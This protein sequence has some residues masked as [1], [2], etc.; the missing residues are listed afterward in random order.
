MG[1]LSGLQY[2]WEQCLNGLAMGSMYAVIA[3]GYSMV[4]GILE[5]INFAHGDVYMVGTFVALTLLWTGLPWWAAFPI[6]LMAGGLLAVL[7]ERLAYA[8]VR[9]GSRIVPMISAVGVAL[10]CRNLAQLTWGTSTYPSPVKVPAITVDAGLI[11]VR[12]EPVLIGA[13]GLVLLVLFNMLLH[14]TRWGLATRIVAQDLTTA[15]LMGIPVERVITLVY[16]IGGVLGVAGGILFG[17]YYNAV[18]IGMGFLG[19][20]KAWIA[21]IIGGIGNLK[22]AFLGGMIL[23]LLEALASGYISSAYRDAISFAIL[24]GILAWRPTGLL[25]RQLAEK[26]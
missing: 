17:M 8:P 6:A 22:G 23:G 9:S 5:L 24:M 14:R 12:S 25:G 19:T 1:G 7:V 18:F 26:V 4:Y 13:I 3:V 2:L 20:M 10:I 11:K 16:A 15:R 21:S